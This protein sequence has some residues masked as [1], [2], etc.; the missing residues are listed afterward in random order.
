MDIVINSDQKFKKVNFSNEFVIFFCLVSTYIFALLHIRIQFKKFDVIN[1]LVTIH[2]WRSIF[3]RNYKTVFKA[4][5]TIIIFL[6][7]VIFVFE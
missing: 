5:P 2:I 7:S 3:C 1:Y 6:N 4:W